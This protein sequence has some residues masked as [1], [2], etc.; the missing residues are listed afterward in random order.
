MLLA[1]WG[2]V[3]ATD[4]RLLPLAEAMPTCS[5]R[6]SPA[7][8]LLCGNGSDRTPH[9]AELLGEDWYRPGDWSFDLDGIE[10]AKS[11]RPAATS[12]RAGAGRTECDGNCGAQCA[13]G[14]ESFVADWVIDESRR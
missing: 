6:C 12:Q 4:Q 13:A 8:D 1:G 14:E 2:C 10:E 7:E 11:I 9:P 5:G 3:C